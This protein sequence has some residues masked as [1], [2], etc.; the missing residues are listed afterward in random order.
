MNS[1]PLVSIVTP[2]FNAEPFLVQCIES[3]LAQTY[4]NWEYII[5]NN[6]STDRTLL[7]AESYMARDARIRVI[8]NRLFVGAIENHNVALQQPAQHSRYCKVVSADD[9]I[10]PD[11][12]TMTVKVAEAHPTVGIVGSYQGR[13]DEVKWMGLPANVE[14]FSGREVCRMALLKDLS[15]FGNPTSSL[16]RTETVRRAG[17]FFP[18]LGPHA[19]TTACYEHLQ[20]CDYGFVHK[21]IS[22]E[23]I[24]Q[25]QISARVRQLNMGALAALEHVL[26]Y[27]PVYLT[28]AEFERTRK[29]A[30]S[31]YYRSMGA[32][33]LKL[34][35]RELWNYH[36]NG[37]N[38]LNQCL[39]WNR[40]LRGAVAELVEEVKTP[41]VAFG[42]AS[43][44]LSSKLRR[45]SHS[46][47]AGL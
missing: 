37:L 20:H 18:H 32:W 5:V 2:A 43:R 29:E 21:V 28:P 10:E 27:G 9:W 11:F 23:R 6:C 34:G 44:V 12:L 4:Q 30:W 16:F 24:H 42:K 46:S 15:I 38:N 40:V 36:R 22:H 35:S 33:V 19:D 13:G 7:I 45:A 25:G 47:V 3:V 39:S 41:N 1:L 31:R 17:R 14:F 8:T 26:K